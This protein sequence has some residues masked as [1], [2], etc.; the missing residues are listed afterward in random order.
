MTLRRLIAIQ[1]LFDR[2]SSAEHQVKS[3][4]SSR[5][6]YMNFSRYFVSQLFHSFALAQKHCQPEGY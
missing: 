5:N 6:N 3:L 1:K 2:V 4:A